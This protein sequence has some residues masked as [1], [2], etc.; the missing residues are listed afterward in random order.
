MHEKTHRV[1]KV[2]IIEVA[3]AVFGLGR[4]CGDVNSQFA[5]LVIGDIMIG[6]DYDHAR[7]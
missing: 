1:G 5:C 2:R 3:P 4:K 7:S 6:G